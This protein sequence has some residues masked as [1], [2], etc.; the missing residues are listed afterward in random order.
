MN[1]RLISSRGLISFIVVLAIWAIA[2]P[3]FIHVQAEPNQKGIEIRSEVG[4]Q[5]AYKDTKG[6]PVK[7]TLTN[8][9]DRDLTGEVVLSVLSNHITATTDYIVPLE[10][11]IGTSV[12]TVIGISQTNVA[13][14]NNLIRFFEGGLNKGNSIPIL[15]TDYLV[16]RA[17]GTNY[18][19]G[20][21]SRDPDTFNF[22]PTLNQKGYG[23]DVLPIDEEDLPQEAFQLDM[24][25]TLVI[26]DFATGNWSKERIAAIEEWVAKGGTLILSGGAGYVKTAEAFQNIAP[27]QATGTTKLPS[28]EALASAGGTELKAD[29]SITISTGQVVEGTVEISE[30][31]VP[32][33][34]NRSV[35]LGT[36]IYA[37]FDPSLA[38]MNTWGGNAPL[39]ANVLQ[40][41][42]IPTMNLGAVYPGNYG[43]IL[44]SMDQA[45]DQFPSIKPPNFWLL[46]V[47]FGIYMIVAAPVLYVVLAKTDRREW[48]WWM[49]PSLSIAMG[50]VIF[51]FG[52][53]D[54][55]QP[56]QHTIEIVEFADDGKVIVSGGTG[57]FSP[58]G[59]TV[60][61]EFPDQRP[62]KMFADSNGMGSLNLNGNHRLVSQ[63]GTSGAE[64][65]S[66]PYWS[67]RKLWME[68][69]LASTEQYGSLSIGYEQ[70]DGKLT[71]IVTNKTN[72]DL[73]NVSLLINGQVKP[74]GTIKK[75]ESGQLA[76]IYMYGSALSNNREY[77]SLI[78][79]HQFYAGKRDT[80]SREREITNAYVNQSNASLVLPTPMIVGYSIDHEPQYTVNGKKVKADNLKMW[81]YKLGTIGQ[82]GGR[83]LVPPNV[84]RPV[85]VSNTIQ[86]ISDYGN[87]IMQVSTGEMIVEYSAPKNNGVKYDT[88]DVQFLLNKPK[89]STGP[90]WTIWNAA[91]GDWVSIPDKPGAAKDFLMKDEKIRFKL[92]ATTEGETSYPNVLLEGEEQP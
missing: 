87:G 51:Y 48:A 88:I 53:G 36:V 11:P 68:R 12:E 43:N 78:F 82:V 26:N 40:K 10:L 66:V 6:F 22:M 55:R 70:K 38:P 35:G 81:V 67:T 15:G 13:K 2:A 90:S 5:G 85:T 19:I 20:V 44:W 39:W 71:L 60:K 41:S 4:F 91:T 16:G 9:T 77:G 73:T 61:A 49:I 72:D 34:V 14:G 1:A 65:H 23:I 92:D 45:L 29:S 46:V 8:K 56:A 21:V 28:T 31:G 37:A 24:L 57:I 7:L 79:P 63:S 47:L 58:T 75:G 69:R 17:L 52:A 74:I 18:T 42:L 86:S 62:L 30:S 32:V 54:K 33:V 89:G 27:F 80:A 76:N 25:D 84:M 50:I 3:P 64:W 59:G 83:I